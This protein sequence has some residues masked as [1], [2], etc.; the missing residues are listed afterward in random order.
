[1]SD[2]LIR[3]TEIPALNNI[4]STVEPTWASDAGR[5]TMEGTWSGT[6]KGYFTTLDLEFNEIVFDKELDIIKQLIE[7]PIIMVT[8]PLEKTMEWTDNKGYHKIKQGEPYT[9]EFYGTA[10]KAKKPF[11]NAKY[12][13]GFSVSLVAVRRRPVY[14]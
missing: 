2:V 6:F 7:H 9:E 12:Y 11:Q 1:M 10:I 8:Y 5:E 3:N 14:D 13:E 4:I